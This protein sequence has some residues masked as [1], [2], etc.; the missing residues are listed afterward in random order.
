MEKRGNVE[1]VVRKVQGLESWAKR[2]E[3]AGRR[4]PSRYAGPAPHYL[5]EDPCIG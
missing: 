3:Y 4:C 1:K 5:F 2:R